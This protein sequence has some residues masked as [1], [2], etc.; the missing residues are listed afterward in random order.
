MSGIGAIFNRNGAPIDPEQLDSLTRALRARGRD[1]TAF[2]LLGH[3]GLAHA[4]FWTTPEDVGE[5]QPI[6][7]PNGKSWITADARLDN[8]EELLPLLAS[9]VGKGVPTDAELILAAYERWGDECPRQLIGD[10]A[11]IL[12]DSR[13]DRLFC[14]RDV[15]GI[16]QMVYC[17]RGATIIVASGVDAVRAILE[18]P[19]ASNDNLLQDLLGGRFDRWV[20][21]T[22]YVGINRVPPSYS[23]S[24]S[25]GSESRSRYWTL[26]GEVENGEGEAARRSRLAPEKQ[27]ERYVEEFR[28]LFSRVTRAQLRS[29]GPVGI[30]VSGGLDSSSA[31]CM[32]ERL[33][34]DGESD[35]TARL[36]SCVFQETP[37]ADEREYL[38]AVLETCKSMEASL[39]CGDDCWAMRDFGEYPMEEPG[40]DMHRLMFLEPLRRAHSD[41]CRVMIGGHWGD[42][43]LTGDPYHSRLPFRDVPL[44]SITRELP[45]FAHHAGMSP[46]SLLANRFLRPMAPSF[47]RDWLFAAGRSIRPSGAAPQFARATSEPITDLLPPPPLANGCALKTYQQLTEGKQTAR[48]VFYDN[49][50]VN[51]GIEMRYPFIDR[52]VVEFLLAVPVWMKFRR[53]ESKF[54]LR[55]AMAGILPEKV[56]KRSKNAHF[57]GL[58]D[59]G[60]RDKERSRVTELL[61]NSRLV[62]GGLVD[63][64]RL[65]QA[66]DRYW[67]SQRFYTERPLMYMLCAEEWLRRQETTAVKE[68]GSIPA[69][70]DAA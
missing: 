65:R 31:A 23:F 48:C 55:E 7:S 41:G 60:L 42:Q 1:G 29:N 13:R 15:I 25:R 19:P 59:R 27:Q 39:I 12:W 61:E 6:A 46:M 14:A 68:N 5:E 3:V 37:G 63:A 43:A 69:R 67:Q 18:P 51:A 44:L 11:F 57:S 64:V 2:R 50:A 22:A 17:E 45:Y 28:A 49:A 10:F 38:D 36:Y 26:G 56:R 30:L 20:K 52:R 58:V 33:I 16:R 54:I 34:E 4:H 21:E 70:R 53:G 8:R 40:I 66:W 35:A 32:A 9:T 62:E 47:L 24:W